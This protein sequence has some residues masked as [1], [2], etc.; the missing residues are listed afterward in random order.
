M[1][2]PFNKYKTEK[3]DIEHICSQTDKTISDDK[4]RL[5][6]INDMLDYFVGEN[7]D[8]SVATHIETLKE[9]IAKELESESIQSKD[10]VVSLKK[11]NFEW[12]HQC[13]N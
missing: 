11:M 7:D 6:W 5:V 1:R 3:W 10:K 8:N 13:I 12:C 9:Q 4:Q 2:F